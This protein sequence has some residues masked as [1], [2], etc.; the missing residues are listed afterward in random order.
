MVTA[1]GLEPEA[2]SRS[3]VRCSIALERG[4]ASIIGGTAGIVVGVMA[5]STVGVTVTVESV[6]G[7]AT[8]GSDTCAAGTVGRGAAAGGRASRTCA[9]ATDAVGADAPDST[10]VVREESG[11]GNAAMHARRESAGLVGVEL[12]A[13]AGDGAGVGDTRPV[14]A[15]AITD[16][17]P[18]A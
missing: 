18:V 10:E 5:A 11:D 2:R 17:A 6:A 8:R 12:Q 1:A 4:G 14:E 16:T 13:A 9:R 15:R 7:G 3:D